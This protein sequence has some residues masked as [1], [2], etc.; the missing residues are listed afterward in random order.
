VY[1]QLGSDEATMTAYVVAVKR[2]RK[3]LIRGRPIDPANES[4][5][6]KYRYQDPTK[7]QLFDYYPVPDLMSKRL[8]A[9]LESAGVDNLQKF[10]A[11]LVDE[12][13]GQVNTDFWVVNIIG[14]V[15][16]ADL[17]SS[18]SSE[19]GSSYYFHE[20][21][22]DPSKAQGLLMFRLAQSA[23]AIL[24]HQKVASAIEQGKFRGVTLTALRESP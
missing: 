24:V 18:K 9:A 17:N 3:S 2:P 23:I 11:E 1:Y 15:E 7:S 14:L 21:V 22:I 20:L 10:E 6:F 12:A 13:T 19:L 16:C 4:P 5:P 8:V